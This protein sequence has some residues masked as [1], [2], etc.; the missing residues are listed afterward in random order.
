M[1]KKNRI[2]DKALGIVH[3]RLYGKTN[4]EGENLGTETKPTDSRMEVRPYL[5]WFSLASH[6]ILSKEVFLANGSCH[7]HSCRSNTYDLRLLSQQTLQLR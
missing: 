6:Q 5:F 4:Q 7:L 1:L 2:V 3:C